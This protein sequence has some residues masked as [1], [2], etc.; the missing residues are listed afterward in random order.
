MA[1]CSLLCPI[2]ASFPSLSYSLDSASWDH[3]PTALNPEYL[4]LNSCI[5]VYIQGS[6]TQ[7]RW[8]RGVKHLDP[9]FVARKWH[10]QHLNPGD[11]GGTLKEAPNSPAS[12]LSHICPSTWDVW[13]CQ[14]LCCLSFWLQVH[15]LKKENS[16]WEVDQPIKRLSAI[17]SQHERFYHVMFFARSL[18]RVGAL[19]GMR[20]GYDFAVNVGQGHQ[21]LRQLE[22]P[23]GESRPSGRQLRGWQKAACPVFPRS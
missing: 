7:S 20:K 17:H 13:D 8:F 9:S 2:L 11:T 10:S 23:E 21:A 5:R 19:T 12:R 18:N 16:I 1:T 14:K 6:P 15:A 4:H 3:L 22:A